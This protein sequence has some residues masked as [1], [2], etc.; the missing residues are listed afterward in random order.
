MDGLCSS[1][2]LG[3]ILSSS[4]H[5]ARSEDIFVCHDWKQGL[6]TSRVRSQGS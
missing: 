1:S 3:L 5:M 2:Y 6:R 4:G